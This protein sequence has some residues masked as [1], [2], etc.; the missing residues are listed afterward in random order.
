MTDS[1]PELLAEQ[2]YVDAAY[3]R[4]DA[5]RRRARRVAAGYSDVRRGGTHQARLERD[6]AEDLTRRRLA[7]LDIGD[8]P[9]CFGRLDLAEAAGGPRATTSADSRSPT[10]TR[11]PAGGRLAGA[12][13]PSRSTGR[14]PSS[15][16]AWSGAGTS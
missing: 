8:P 2:R 11:R 6:A 1:H 12:G 16:W 4:L 13:R 3:S 14:P 9:L 5:M 15:P 7:A 10:T